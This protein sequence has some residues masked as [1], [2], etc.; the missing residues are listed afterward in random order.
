[1]HRRKHSSFN[2]YG[3]E[4][5]KAPEFDGPVEV[6][7]GDVHGNEDDIGW[8]AE[9]VA[10]KLYSLAENEGPRC[11]RDQKSLPFIGRP[12]LRCLVPRIEDK[13]I[14]WKCP[15]SDCRLEDRVCAPWLGPVLRLVADN[16]FRIQL[17]YLPPVVSFD[18]QAGQI[19][20]PVAA[21]PS[22]TLAKIFRTIFECGLHLGF[23]VI[24]HADFPIVCIKPAGDEIVVVG[25]ELACPPLFVGKSVGEGL[26]LQDAAAIRSTASGKT[27]QTAVDV[28]TCRA[29]EVAAFQVCRTQEIPHTDILRSLQS[30]RGTDATHL[31]V[32]E[33]RQHPLHHLFRPDDI[34]VNK[35]GEFRSDLWDGP[36]HLSTFVRFPDA[37]DS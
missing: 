24:L 19:A 18:E 3:V 11:Q 32:L 35:D 30:L 6:A 23:L 34:V 1:M 36:A 28:E 5:Q 20:A 4:S 27:W 16:C 31:R 10:P 21:N 15:C 25:I 8:V 7:K 12:L 17:G 9:E 14:V 2:T 37:E 22:E 13:A 26:V 29:I 33:W